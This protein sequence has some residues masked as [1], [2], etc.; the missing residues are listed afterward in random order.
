MQ[1]DWKNENMCQKI[2]SFFPSAFLAFIFLTNSCGFPQDFSQPDQPKSISLKVINYNLWHGL[3]IG[4]FKREVLESSSHKSQRYQEQIKLLKKAKPDILFLQELNPVGSL[5]KRI[6][7][8][9]GMFS[10][11]QNTNC[12][13][14]ILGFGLPTNLDMGISILVRP[15]LEIKKILGVKLSG[16]F[17]ACTP[18]FTFQYSEFR[19]ALFAL[20]YHPHHGSL[21]LANT[22]LHHGVEWSPQVR[23]KI[24]FWE[25]TGILTKSQR[26]ELEEVIE[27]SNQR[28]KQEL[29]NLFAH[30]KELMSYYKQPP[31][32]L[33]GD[34]NSTVES[35]IYK[36]IVETYKLKDSVEAYSPEPFTW[37]PLQNKKNHQYTEKFGISV[38][39]FDKKEIE[40]F[41]KE[42]DRRQRRI[43]YIF[44]SPNIEI[45]SQ[46]LFAAEPNEQGIIGSDHFGVLVQIQS[47]P[48]IENPL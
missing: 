18:Y 6:A 23:A 46:E 1:K 4:F 25:K 2:K 10:V 24:D 17:G 31:F 3:G 30:K 28:R 45:L 44:V 29:N 15:P 22:H 20:A 40:S 37:N 34:F 16:P 19:Y 21:L 43:D 13:I 11:F 12:G 5:S 32:I 39:S 33:A 14:S 42:Y 9:L 27:Q 41:F 26:K 48:P 38:P 47:P 35:P 8:E 36:S 7:K